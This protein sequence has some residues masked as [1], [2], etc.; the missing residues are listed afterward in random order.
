AERWPEPAAEH[1][2]QDGILR[3]AYARRGGAEPYGDRYPAHLHIDLL[4]EA[5]R[6]GLGRALIDTLIDALRGRGVAGLHLA[7]SIGNTDA[8]AFYPRVGF[9]PLPSHPGVQAFGRAIG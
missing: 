8:I 3:Y 4:P 6:Q 9:P 5:Q 7:A 1:T 2:R